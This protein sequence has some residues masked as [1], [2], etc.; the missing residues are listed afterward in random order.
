MEEYQPKISFVEIIILTQIFMIFDAIGMVLILFGLD[1]FFILDALRFPFSQF[2]IYMKGLKGGATLV[3]NLLETIPYIGALPNSTVCWLITVY[4]DR[5]PKSF[6]AKIVQKTGSI[7]RP[8]RPINEKS[9]SKMPGM[10][11]QLA[12]EKSFAGV[13]K[14]A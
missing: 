9:P 5:N 13:K 14:A 1:D 2:Y 7:T 4:M 3:G 8:R 10:A 11:P 12:S 6:A